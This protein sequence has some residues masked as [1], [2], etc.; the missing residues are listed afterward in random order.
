MSERYVDL[1]EKQYLLALENYNSYIE[2]TYQHIR[3]FKHDYENMMLSL[4]GSLEQNDPK[5][6]R[7]I[8]SDILLKLG[9]DNIEISQFYQERFN[10]LQD[11][12][13]EFFLSLEFYEMMKNG[14]DTH[15]DIINPISNLNM[16]TMDLIVLLRTIFDFTKASLAS[17]LYP[18]VD[19]LVNSDRQGNVDVI[20]KFS[21]DNKTQAMPGVP[22]EIVEQNNLIFDYYTDKY[23]NVFIYREESA[24][25]YHFRIHMLN[26][27]VES[28][29]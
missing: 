27:E 29:E 23:P 12:D 2:R 25:D 15:V 10:Q 8:S 16:S 5:L 6:V 4:A 11:K 24:C 18:R 26:S 14:V 3:S 20:I 19:F 28:K 17:R 21:Y 7:R 9:Q 1:V 13:L 22:M